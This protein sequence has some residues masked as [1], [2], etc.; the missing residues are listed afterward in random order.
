MSN[1]H[2]RGVLST[3]MTPFDEDGRLALHLIEPFLAWQAEN[4][5]AGVYVLGTWGGF[6]LLDLA[7]RRQ[8]AEAYC[9][10]AR[11]L[12]LQIIVHI[13]T[14]SEADTLELARHAT[15][16]GA[17]A[18]SAVI[19]QYYSTG[20]YLG[21]GDYKRY[22]ERLVAKTSAPLYVYNNPR[23]TNVLLT[24]EEYVELA[25]IGVAGVKDGSKNVAWVT[26]AQEGLAA[27]GLEGQIIPGN[28]VGLI[29]G[30]IYGCDAVTS[31]GA[32]VF[33]DEAA[34]IHRLLD[35]GDVAAAVRQHRY[36]LALRAAI[37]LCSAPPAAAHSLLNAIGHSLGVG[38]PVWPQVDEQLFDKMF[39]AID[40]AKTMYGTDGP[41]AHSA[42]DRQRLPA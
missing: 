22:F 26:K 20:G 7:E 18:I 11:R 34:Q 32:V 30:R 29:Y 6:A 27:A 37:G 36:V 39:R 2:F 41:P 28:T 24:P 42:E 33:P 16:H 15:D 1:T 12:G 25:G 35:E 23:T 4:G 3:P 40:A 21:K 8:V 13:G 5:I 19:P 31:G 14:Y 38:R 9:A 17:H 10:A